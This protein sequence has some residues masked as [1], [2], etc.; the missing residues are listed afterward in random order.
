MLTAIR[1]LVARAMVRL[2]IAAA[3]GAQGVAIE[4]ATRPIWRPG[5]K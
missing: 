4:A 1:L 3:P 5:D 2:A